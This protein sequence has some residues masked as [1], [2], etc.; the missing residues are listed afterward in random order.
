MP[1]HSVLQ[2]INYTVDEIHF[3][4]IPT[5]N[6]NKQFE[7]EPK[8]GRELND[9]G[10]DKYDFSLSVEIDSKEDHLMPFEIAVT[11]TGHFL[12]KEAE[13]DPINDKMKKTLLLNNTAAILFPFLRSIVATVTSN[14][15]MPALILPVM[16]F[17]ADKQE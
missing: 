8:F 6:E 2:F 4:M 13:D 15:N 5:E 16:N 9:L 14:A 1:K 10:D 17:S 12:L 7:F 3:K 11:L